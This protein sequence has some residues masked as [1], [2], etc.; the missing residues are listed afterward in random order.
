[1][2]N[3]VKLCA[4]GLINIYL[5]YTHQPTGRAKL[6]LDVEEV[7]RLSVQTVT[8]ILAVDSVIHTRVSFFN[9]VI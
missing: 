6:P 7:E 3:C 1:L 2:N 8:K 9:M 5:K 4:V